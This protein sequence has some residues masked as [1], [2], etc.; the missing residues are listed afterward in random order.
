MAICHTTHEP[1]KCVYIALDIG[2]TT[3]NTQRRRACVLIGKQNNAD[4]EQM[5]TMLLWYVHQSI[6]MP[7]SV[8]FLSQ[9]FKLHMTVRYSNCLALDAPEISWTKGLRFEGLGRK[10]LDSKDSSTFYELKTT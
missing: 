2:V 1:N 7:L 8:T 4:G 9:Y 3:R 6:Q 10:V 5:Q